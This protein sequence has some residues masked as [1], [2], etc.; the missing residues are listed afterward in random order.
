MP[1]SVGFLELQRNITTNVYFTQI[2]FL[3]TPP[4]PSNAPL[5]GAPTFFSPVILVEEI[6][7]EEVV[8][9]YPCGPSKIN[10]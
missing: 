7:D 4:R 3:S 1:F 10:I 5:G 8:G 6:V 9:D 2:K